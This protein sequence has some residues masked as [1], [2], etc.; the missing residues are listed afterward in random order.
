MRVQLIKYTDMP[1]YT[2]AL[3]AR[4]CYSS[5]SQIGLT[6]EKVKNL[7]KKILKS[8]HLSVLEHISFTYLIEGISRVTTHQLVRHR[9]ASYSQQSHRY[10]KIEENKF[11]CPPDIQNDKKAYDIYEKAT[12]DAI[13]TYN[14]LIEMGIKKEDARYIIPQAVTSNIM[15]TMNARELLHFFTL[16]CCKR[17][18]WEIREVANEMLRLA[19]QK[20]PII[21]ENA[22]PACVRG[23]CPEEK[24]CKNIKEIRNF[25]KEL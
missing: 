21:F 3:A 4:I 17:A 15:V 12:K 23:R 6:N 25:F 8:G 7:I 20:A 13:K 11:V 22:G 1:D 2:A 24:P 16:R 14:K 19:K 9:L 5:S 10:T 18:Q